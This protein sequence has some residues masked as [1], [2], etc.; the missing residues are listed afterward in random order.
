VI[1]V[2]VDPGKVT[3]IAVWRD[4][5][6]RDD[7][8]KPV[9]AE[10]SESTHVPAQIRRLLDGDRP[11]L[12]AVERCRQNPRKSSQPEAMEVTGAV[13]S[14]AEAFTVRC[15]YQP[16]NP[17]LTLAKRHL[18]KLG[19]YVKSKDGHENAAQGH[20]LLLLATYAPERFA[21]LIGI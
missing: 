6:L 15:V 18:R 17:A 21:R 9:T 20:L 2:A 11:T 13:R 7:L 5:I 14:L 1:L 12:M 19:W 10:V 8:I 4:F 16:P 3:G